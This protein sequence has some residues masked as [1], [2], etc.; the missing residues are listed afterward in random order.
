MPSCARCES[1][2]DDAPAGSDYAYCESCMQLFQAVKREGV[3]VAS[4]HGAHDFEQW[5]YEAPTEDGR[6]HR[7]VEALAAALDEMDE[8]GVRGVF[9]YRETGSWWLISSY[10]D[11]HPWIADDVEKERTDFFAD[12]FPKRA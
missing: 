1:Q 12:L 6:A 2:T 11:A 9:H 3:Y 4:R 7:Q 10:L 8:R 5:P